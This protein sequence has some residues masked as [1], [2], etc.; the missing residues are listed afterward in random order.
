[1]KTIHLAKTAGF[2]MGVALALKK[3]DQAI[4]DKKDGQEI[5]TQGP[6]IHNP[7]VLEYYQSQGVFECQST[8]QL[9]PHCIV[10]IR[11][12]GI[13][14]DMQQ[15]IEKSGA[16]IVD[17]TC[18]KVKKAQTLIAKNSVQGR[19]LLL[20]GEKDHP[21]VKG[22]VSYAQ[23]GFTVFESIQ[24]LETLLSTL[25]TP[26][27]LAAQTT[28]DREEFQ[29]IHAR[30]VNT[31]GEI[32]VMDTICTATKERQQ[33][34]IAIAK[35]VDLMVVVGGKNSGNTRRLAQVA[36]ATTT[37]CC[38]VERKEE[39]PLEDLTACTT[40]GLTAGASTPEDVINDVFLYLLELDG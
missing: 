7:Q 19:H 31:L 34:A 23:A 10:V 11:A 14:L 1:M 8:K 15:A 30:L 36:S 5:F 27:F 12:H 22:L 21:E 35:E 18:P 33:E 2:C 16:T 29:D 39:L 38:H 20:F 6:I 17:A 9:G 25:T 26:C 24:E 37:P 3:L 4:A 28:Q 13:P 40:I 32:P